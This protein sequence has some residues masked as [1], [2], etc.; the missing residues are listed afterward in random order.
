MLKACHPRP[1]L[2]TSAPATSCVAQRVP[3]SESLEWW[4]HRGHAQARKSKGVSGKLAASVGRWHLA[5]LPHAT[6]CFIGPTA[7]CGKDGQRVVV[8]PL[9]CG[10]RRTSTKGQAATSLAHATHG[11]ME[12]SDLLL[13]FS[14]TPLCSLQHRFALWSAPICRPLVIE[15]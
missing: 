1:R 14:L 4:V 3:I 12:A 5:T 15:E 10:C 7:G 11:S 9:L 2:Q 8:M 6:L 13:G